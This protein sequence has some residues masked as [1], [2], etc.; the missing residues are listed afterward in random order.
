MGQIQEIRHLEDV[1]EVLGIRRKLYLS[2]VRSKVL[3]SRVAARS[4]NLGMGVSV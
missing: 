2:T 1:E 3:V 4:G